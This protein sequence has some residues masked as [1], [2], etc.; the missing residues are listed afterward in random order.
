[1]RES[2]PKITVCLITAALLLAGVLLPGAAWSQDD[3]AI[4]AC[5]DKQSTMDIVDCLEKL[6]AQWD[7]KLNA[8]YQAALKAADADAV[9][10]L[11]A[12]ERAWLEFRKQRCYYLG[13]G[14]GTIGRVVASDCFMRMTKARAEELIEDAK[15]LGPG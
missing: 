9:G 8:A 7:K 1:M 14:P 3:R 4:D 10:P 15:G 6:T 2:S 5:H 11:R 12:S 13:A